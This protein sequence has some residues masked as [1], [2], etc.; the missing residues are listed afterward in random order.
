MPHVHPVGI[1]STIEV[2]YRV[3]RTDNPKVWVVL[4]PGADGMHF[5]KN[6]E[7]FRNLYTRQRP[8]QRLDLRLSNTRGGDR[9]TQNPVPVYTEILF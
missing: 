1:G 3:A 5:S 7:P 6:K 2:P 8:P 4:L 9:S